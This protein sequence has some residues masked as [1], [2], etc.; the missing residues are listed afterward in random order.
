[1]PHIQTANVPLLLYAVLILMSCCAYLLSLLFD[2]PRLSTCY[3]LYFSLFFF[4]LL[5]LFCFLRCNSHS[6][7]TYKYIGCR[8]GYS[9]M[10]HFIGLKKEHQKQN[11]YAVISW[12]PV[13]IW[14][15]VESSQVAR[16]DENGKL[17][18]IKI[19]W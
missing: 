15:M 1:M 13:V 2:S 8:S 6:H 5:I 7:F 12:P 9:P 3:C 16:Q 18:H 14:N 4:F 19:K 11:K 17:R 10:T